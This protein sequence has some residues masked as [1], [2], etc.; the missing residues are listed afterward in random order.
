[1]VLFSVACYLS[2]G[3]DWYLDQ[4]EDYRVPTHPVVWYFR[5][6]ESLCRVFM[7]SSI[8]WFKNYL[9]VSHKKKVNDSSN[10]KLVT[11]LVNF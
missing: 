10:M 11:Y 7:M 5:G 8:L 3:L 2:T 4:I 1:M 6:F 9:K